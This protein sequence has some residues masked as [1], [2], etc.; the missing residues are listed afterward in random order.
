MIPA[1]VEINQI[2]WKVYEDDEDWAGLVNVYKDSSDAFTGRIELTASGS[3]DLIPAGSGYLE[4]TINGVTRKMTFDWEDLYTSSTQDDLSSD[5]YY[6]EQTVYVGTGETATLI[7]KYMQNHSFIP[8]KLC[9][10]EI[11]RAHV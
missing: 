4:V 6:N 11:G 5:A 3:S 2:E 7:A 1:D 8:I 10:A 9:T